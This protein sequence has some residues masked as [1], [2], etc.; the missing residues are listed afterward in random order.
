M[1][2]R[3]RLSTPERRRNILASKAKWRDANREYYREQKRLLT[4]RP[5]YRERRKELREQKHTAPE[6]VPDPEP[7]N[8]TL[9]TWYTAPHVQDDPSGPVGP[10]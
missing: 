4:N 7:S 9:W 3:P 10:F 6:V 2:G 1:A 5:E 8:I